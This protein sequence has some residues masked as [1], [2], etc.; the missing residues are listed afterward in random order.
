MLDRE[1]KIMGKEIEIKAKIDNINEVL[2][3]LSNNAVFK[4]S[5]S[6]QDVLYDFVPRSFILDEL[7]LKADEFIRIR[8]TEK[9]DFLT[10]KIILRDQ[11]NNFL[12][13]DEEEAVIKSENLQKICNILSA[14]DVQNI[15]KTDCQSG[16]TLGTFLEENNFKKL[17]IIMKNRK[18]YVLQELNIAIDEVADLGYFIEIESLKSTQDE[19]LIK[20]IKNQE[21][22]ILKKLKIPSNN[23]VNK[24]YSD[25]L[26]ENK[27]KLFE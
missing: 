8:C 15:N 22:N 9:E 16:K 2:L 7:T 6:Q 11:K 10:H 26:T 5:I 25:L 17:I 12:C 20:M 13:C 19:K 1:I 23:I 21:A 4:R 18:E 14:F 24:G 3:W 27:T